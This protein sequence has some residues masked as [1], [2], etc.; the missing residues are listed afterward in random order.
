MYAL[1]ENSKARPHSLA[2]NKEN[3]ALLRV[4]VQI[5]PLRGGRKKIQNLQ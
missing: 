1:Y 3:Q 4:P 2:Q 5:C